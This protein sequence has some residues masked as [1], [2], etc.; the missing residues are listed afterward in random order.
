MQVLRQYKESDLLFYDLECVRVAKDY[1]SLAPG[2][3]DAWDYKARHFNEMERKT[4]IVVTPE[5]FYM[6]KAGLYAPFSKIVCISV[7]RIDG[8]QLKTR[9][10]FGEE[11]ELLVGFA[12]FISAKPTNI[13]A[14]FNIIGFDGPFI[15]KRMLVNDVLIPPLLDIA[16]Q[17]P[18]DVVQLDLSKLWQGN[19]YYP[20]SL[21]AVSAALNIPSPK[22]NVESSQ[23]SDLFYKGKIKDI[24]DYCVGDVLA[25]A[26]IYRRF[27]Q[28]SLVTLQ[29]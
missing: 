18:W 2:L 4:G 25:T 7:G 1:A 29:P 9:S 5:E 14:G 13:L 17:K 12:Q 26:N 23:V 20:D 3:Q 6:E 10:F 27:M 8:D 22:G 11:A 21:A 19:S 28:K 16:G 24:V 15:S